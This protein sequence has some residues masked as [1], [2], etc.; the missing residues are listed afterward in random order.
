MFEL[1]KKVTKGFQI[2]KE[3]KELHRRAFEE[4]KG[5]IAEAA[6]LSHPNYKMPLHMYSDASDFALGVY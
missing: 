2:K 5:A 6:I 1:T 3:W 4:L